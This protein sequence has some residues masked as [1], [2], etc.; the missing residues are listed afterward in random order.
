ME[1]T[2]ILGLYAGYIRIMEENMESTTLYYNR[3]YIGS[4]EKRMETTIIGLYRV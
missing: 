2:R 4:M 3:G 1:T